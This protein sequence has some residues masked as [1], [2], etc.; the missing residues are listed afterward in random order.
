MPDIYEEL[1][2]KMWPLMIPKKPEL[3]DI[4]KQLYTSKEAEFLLNAFSASFEEIKTSKEI[5]R[6]TG[7]SE[8]EVQKILDSLSQ[9][10]L[11]LKF[12]YQRINDTCYSLLPMVPGFFELYYSRLPDSR[13]KTL[14]AYL[15]EK[16]QEN[17]QSMEVISS[18]YPWGRIIPIEKTIYSSHEV[19]PFEKI[20]EL[21]KTSHS[22]AVIPCACRIEN[23]CKHPT[24][25]CIVF[26]SSAD[27]M[28][29]KGI[30][31]YLTIKEALDNLEKMEKEGLMHITTNSQEKPRFICSCCICSCFFL[32]SLKKMSNPRTF[33]KSNFVAQKEDNTCILCGTCIKICPLDAF[34]HY[35]SFDNETEKVI[36][37]DERCVGCGLCVYHCPADAIKL[38]K[39]GNE[40]PEMTPREAWV[41]VEKERVKR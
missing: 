32:R 18:N 9:R 34:F 33:A 41:R 3:I 17:K 6:D 29:D 2:R 36:L 26:D 30:G 20:S 4:L 7:I 28:V 5:A 38:V 11:I 24:E 40:V 16:S 23:P 21:I 39:I 1:K 12:K 27:L 37:K 13:E 10:G 22:I 31:Q 8:K 19:L 15:F 35:R 25:V 14:I